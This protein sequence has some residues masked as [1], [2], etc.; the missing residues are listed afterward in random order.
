MCWHLLIKRKKSCSFIF[1]RI[2]RFSALYLRTFWFLDR[3]LEFRRLRCSSPNCAAVVTA[4]APARAQR[5]RQGAV[6]QHRSVPSP[7]PPA[8]ANGPLAVWRAER[9]SGGRSRTLRS[10]RCPRPARGRTPVGGTLAGRGGAGRGPAP[11]RGGG[12]GTRPIDSSALPC[13]GVP[14]PAGSDR[15]ACGPPIPARHR[16]G[17]R[18]REPR[19]V[20]ARWGR[21]AARHGAA[22]PAPGRP[23][24]FL[25]R[26]PPAELVCGCR[27]RARPEGPLPASRPSQGSAP[28]SW[29]RGGG[30]GLPRCPL[31]LRVRPGAAGGRAPHPPG[32]WL[33]PVP[34]GRASRVPLRR[35]PRV[36]QAG[37]PRPLG[38]FLKALRPP[39]GKVTFRCDSD[40]RCVPTGLSCLSPPPGVLACV[41]REQGESPEDS[42]PPFFCVTGRWVQCPPSPLADRQ[43]HPSSLPSL[44]RSL[45]APLFE[46]PALSGPVSSSSLEKN[47]VFFQKKGATF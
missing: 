15:L 16:G 20:P 29:L 33:A 34:R 2:S 42:A 11:P 1:T 30:E 26:Q 6:P 38:G 3:V 17:G 4:P 27:A 28:P 10:P 47:H 24:L 32:L 37:C 35:P 41:E 25:L 18:H 40:T 39:L 46:G 9:L 13:P 14:P 7:W 12:R 45:S 23:G 21:G 22:P 44:P 5:L 19:W 8:G 31:S 36:A 43:H